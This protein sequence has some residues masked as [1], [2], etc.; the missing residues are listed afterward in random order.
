MKGN[1]SELSLT[2]SERP[3]SKC[4]LY[5]SSSLVQCFWLEGVGM[6]SIE[7]NATIKLWNQDLKLITVLNSRQTDVYVNCAAFHR[8][9]LAICDDYGKFQVSFLKV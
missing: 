8:N 7:N 6:L 2:D 1:L 9:I 3:D 4:K 5:K